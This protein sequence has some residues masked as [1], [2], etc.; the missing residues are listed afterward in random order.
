MRWLFKVAAF[1]A[2]SLVLGGKFAYSIIQKK[3]LRSVLPTRE[4][5]MQKFQVGM[6]YLEF[7]K[8]LFKLHQLRQ[9][10]HINIGS[11]WIPTIPLLFYSVGVER[12]VL[13]DIRRNLDIEIVSDVVQTFREIA[14]ERS[15]SER[16]NFQRVPPLVEQGEGLDDYFARLGTT[17]VVPYESHDF[18][19]ERG[20]KLITCTQVLLY[21]N[22]EQLN[23]LFQMIASGLAGDGGIF[24]ATVHLYDLYSNFDRSISRYNKWRYSDFTWE[25]V[26]NSKLMSFNRLTA[27]DYRQLLENYGFEILEF[28]VT[29]PTA[30]D[31][32]VLRRT[33]IHEKFRHI[34]ESELA[35]THLFFA[36]KLK[37]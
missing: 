4:R 28:R 31:L 19:R 35:A 29:E 16:G 1:K 9:A 12:Q 15:A 21:L 3:L 2:L 14:R 24:I 32:E 23:S 13:C 27:S 11:G 7:L 18:L 34:P 20:Y 37:D 17:Y 6:D 10:I 5:V 8:Q 22:K 33:A 25:R 26:I 36:A 30:S